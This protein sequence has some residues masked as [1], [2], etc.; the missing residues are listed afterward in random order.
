LDKFTPKQF[1]TL[2]ILIGNLL[3]K[4]KLDISVV[5]GHYEYDTAILQGKTCPNFDVN[6]YRN[7]LY[8]LKE[9]GDVL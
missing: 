2:T 6:C 7:E 1:E 9:I 8:L 5:R 3:K 4:Y